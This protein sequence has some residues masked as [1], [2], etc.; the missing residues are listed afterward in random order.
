MQ[1]IH[2]GIGIFGHELVILAFVSAIVSAFAYITASQKTSLADQASWKK[3]ARIA[4][5]VHGASLFGVVLTL[6]SIIYNHYF[7]YHYAWSHASVNLPTHYMISCFW[8]GQEGSFLLW[9]FWHV[10]IGLVLLRTAKQWENHVMGIFV[11][12][13]AFLV[14][15]ILGVVPIDLASFTLK[16]GSD[17]FILLRDALPNDMQ[18]KLNPNFVPEDG[19]GLNPLLQNYWMVIHPPTL[20]LG[21]AFTLVPFAYCIAGLQTK[22]YSAWIKP[23]L[24]WSLVGSL[25]LGVG[26][27][28]GA[29]WAY[30]T[31]NFGGYWNWD[32]VENAVYIPWLTWVAAIH[33]MAVYQRSK[34]GLKAGMIL[35]ITTFV[36]ILYSTFLVR[37]GILGET[38][39]HAF[40]DLGLSGQLLMYL[41]VFTLISIVLLMVRWKQIPS[42]Q[43]EIDTYTSEF[44]I[45]IGAT[46]LVLSAFQVLIPTSIPLYNSIINAFGGVSKVA[47][48]ADQVAFYTE[49]QLWFAVAIAILSGTG[50]MFWWKKIAPKKVLEFFA[51]PLILTFIL[52]TVIMMVWNMKT[53][54]FIALL[55][56]SIYSIVTNGQ[57]LL[58][59]TKKNFKVAGGAVSHIG[60][61]IMLIGI[62]FSS[63]F[64]K[65]VS[66]NT[67]GGRP[68][69]E[70]F[71]DE[72][73]EKNWLVFQDQPIRVRDTGRTGVFVSESFPEEID[74]TQL[75]ELYI[76]GRMMVKED[77]VAD[78]K[79]YA[80]VGDTINVSAP[81]Y[82]IIYK[83]ARM[84]SKEVPGYVDIEHLLPTNDIFKKIARKKIEKEGKVYKRPGDTLHVYG[85]NTYFEIDYRKSDGTVHTLYPRIQDNE[86][87][88]MVSSP[89]INSFWNRD[90]YIHVTNMPAQNQEINWS[91]PTFDT[92]SMGDRF[93]VNDFIAT[94]DTFRLWK[95]MPGI[96]LKASEVV[97]E[98][99]VSVQTKVKKHQLLPR[100]IADTQTGQ[101]RWIPDLN[102]GIGVVLSLVN[103]HSDE[104]SGAQQGFNPKTQRFVFSTATTQSDW[105][106]L[107]A[108]EK[109]FINLLW[110]GT[111]IMGLGFGIAAS[112]R[113]K[114]KQ[115]TPK[116]EAKEEKVEV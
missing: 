91:D 58:F 72:M 10:L 76:P 83:G 30:E 70:D 6:F 40:T 57:M 47:P 61:A 65:V 104:A 44:W 48:P 107:N 113:F 14:S 24:S 115:V 41:L 31:L 9:A 110:I 60:I 17:P 84:E 42:S 1:E 39:V 37:S 28:M 81:Y 89:D 4:F 8:E 77:L 114:E 27:M 98:A 112:R 66:S 108:L 7:E 23:A 5:Y 80:S 49:K 88:G 55:L 87:M 90:I 74:S 56:A 54:S 109:P 68:Y 102:K 36:L 105:I 32:P 52:T 79:V 19:T 53:P 67:N 46:V 103:L 85:E 101:I 63:G 20:F 95:K 78:G 62:L 100:M 75:Q 22:Q 45:F 13:Q 43:K 111:I 73:N 50:Q 35:T 38:S 99:Q 64:S 96:E 106:I 69:R 21:F 71:P 25:I 29:Y 15:M 94:F 93:I 2:T 86:R 82:E 116:F 59:L 33:L 3:M 97:F 26:I 11:L 92:L 51:I 12:V 18:F 16:I 34:T